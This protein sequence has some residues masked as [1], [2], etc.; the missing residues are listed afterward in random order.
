MAKVTKD[1]LKVVNDDINNMNQNKPLQGYKQPTN[2][3]R[4]LLSN[5]N[6][7]IQNLQSG[8]PLEYAKMK[9]PTPAPV[10]PQREAV[11]SYLQ[12]QKPTSEEQALSQR[13]AQITGETQ[14]AQ[15]MIGGEPISAGAMQGRKSYLSRESLAQLAPL[16]TRLAALM[17]QREA[18]KA[19]TIGDTVYSPTGEVLY[20]EPTATE[21][22]KP[23]TL[24]QGQILVDPTT[25]EQIATGLPEEEEVD[26]SGIKSVQGGLYDMATNQWIVEPK[27]ETGDSMTGMPASFK[28]WSLAGGEKGTGVTY[29]EWVNPPQENQYGAKITETALDTIEELAPQ[30][31]NNTVGFVGANLS[32]IYGTKAYNFKSALDTLKSNIAFGALTEMRAASKTGGALGQVSDR[33][34]ELLQSS[35]GALD[36]GQSPEAFRA[37]LQKIQDSLQRWS[38]AVQSLNEQQESLP[39]TM[40]LNGEILH[41]QSDGTYK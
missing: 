9:A 39:Q 15:T 16:Q 5:I 3:D 11:T 32:K 22:M 36:N 7:D 25:G 41:L 37:Q 13:I 18:Q 31:S 4:S 17:A 12:S 23:I 6:T 34:G 24:S 1:V 35:L 38:S 30:V 20:Q 28:E 26:Y 21:A 2:I 29:N 33:E 19:Q 27:P 10:S 8:K 40:E 14:G